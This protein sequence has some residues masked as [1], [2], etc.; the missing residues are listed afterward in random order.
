MKANNLKETAEDYRWFN[1]IVFLSGLP[2]VFASGF[3]VW[4]I[5]VVYGKWWSSFNAMLMG[6]AWVLVSLGF[7]IWIS[8]SKEF[9]RE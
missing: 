8:T 2:I 6:I 9:P 4:T 3:L 7:L 1:P 5:L